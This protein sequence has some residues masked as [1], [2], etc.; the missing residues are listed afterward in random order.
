MAFFAEKTAD[1][2]D[3]VIALLEDEPAGDQACAPFINFVSMLA[4]VRVNV[5]L[6]NT[7]N[8]R[9]NFGPHAGAGAH[10]A[11]FVRGVKDKVGQVAAIAA[12]YVFQHF[13][14]DVLDA[15]SRSFH[16]IPGAGNDRLAFAC[17]AR[18]DRANGI[19]AAVT[20]SFGLGDREFH[21]FLF[22]FVGSGDHVV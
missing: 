20:G 4:A 8:D 6:R 21:E 10:G 2:G 7:V 14:L 22:R 12:G 17:H 3:V 5:L 1:H 15:G 9:A 16:P 13:Q 11:G 19:V 18:D